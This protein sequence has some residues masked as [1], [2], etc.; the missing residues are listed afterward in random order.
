MFYLILEA[1]LVLFLAPYA[2]ANE[3]AEKPA[4]QEAV[5]EIKT[6]EDSFFTVQARVQALEAKIHSAETE[7]SK[8]IAEKNKTTDS[9]KVTEIIRQ[10][11]TLHRELENNVKE[12]D[13]QRTL[14]K[15]RYPDKGVSAKREYERINVRSIEEMENHL[16]VNAALNKTLKK[17][18]SQFPLKVEE[19]DLAEHQ[20]TSTE[21]IKNN[22][23]HSKSRSPASPQNNKFSVDAI[24]LKK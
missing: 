6:N 8:L 4:Q 7:I 3:G 15:Y 13:Q 18:R 20:N 9:E 1:V 24:I 17:V 11:I 22:Q 19:R 2:F 5:A 21:K 12:Y 14:L 16:N 23:E 10:M